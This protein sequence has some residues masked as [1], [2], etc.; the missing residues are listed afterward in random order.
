MPQELVGLPIFGMLTALFLFGKASP[1]VYA[2]E[3]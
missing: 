2:E 1:Y 3:V